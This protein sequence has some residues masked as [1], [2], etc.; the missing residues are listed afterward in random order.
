[1]T[2]TNEQIF[3]INVIDKLSKGDSY[4]FLYMLSNNPELIESS[5]DLL[6]KQELMTKIILSENSILLELLFRF[7]PTLKDIKGANSESLIMLAL[8]QKNY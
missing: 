4:W 7:Y 5:F 3:E 8:R 1:M 2:N 6:D